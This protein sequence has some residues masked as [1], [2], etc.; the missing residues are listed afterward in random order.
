MI[1]IAVGVPRPIIIVFAGY[2]YGALG[3]AWAMSAIAVVNAVL[4]WFSYLRLGP[5]NDTG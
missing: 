3:A 5:G 4:W 1:R 2:Q